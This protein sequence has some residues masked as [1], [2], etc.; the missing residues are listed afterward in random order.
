MWNKIYLIKN[1]FLKFYEVRSERGYF[2]WCRFW[3][4]F[5]AA[6]VFVTSHSLLFRL[7]LAI[8]CVP[9]VEIEVGCFDTNQTLGMYYP[10]N[11]DFTFLHFLKTVWCWCQ[12]KVIYFLYYFYG[13]G[14]DTLDFRTICKFRN[15]SYFGILFMKDCI[16]LTKINLLLHQIT[17]LAC[18]IKIP[19]APGI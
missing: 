1:G 19:V 15:L 8:L 3:A 17:S 4:S 2:N 7:A 18:E 12:N 14:R 11:G 5:D 6:V 9:A 13:F 16:I 10:G